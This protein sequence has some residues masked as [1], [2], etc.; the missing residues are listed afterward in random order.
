M[1]VSSVGVLPEGHPRGPAGLAEVAVGEGG[2]T[3]IPCGYTE[4]KRAAEA[5]VSAAIREGL[6]GIIAR[7]SV[8]AGSSRSGAWNLDDAMCRII[9]GCIQAGA[10]PE[11]EWWPDLVPV[12]FVAEAIVALGERA[13][14]DGSIF[15][16][17]SGAPV[18]FARIVEVARRRGYHVDWLGYDAWLERLEGEGEGNALGPLTPWI[19]QARPF[20]DVRYD[21]SELTRALAEG[22]VRCPAID[23]A[24]LERYFDAFVRAEFLAPPR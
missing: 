15:H 8:V 1:H 5:L 11:I 6:P 22:A 20:V 7:P 24:L 12:D 2:R 13:K 14:V 3:L 21:R 17:T 18:P 16:V 10:A 23:D 19:R 9:K 4:T